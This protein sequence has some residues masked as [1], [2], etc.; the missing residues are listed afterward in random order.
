MVGEGRADRRIN[1]FSDSPEMEVARMAPSPSETPSTLLFPSFF[2]SRLLLLLFHSPSPFQSSILSQCLR[3]SKSSPI[4]LRTLSVRDLSSSSAA[5]SPTSAS[6]SRSARL[7]AW[8]FWLW[9]VTI[10]DNCCRLT[11]INLLIRFIRVLLVTSSS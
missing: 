2:S 8:D 7:L 3:L 5:P 6:S 10:S 9:Y 11:A 4:S 1:Q